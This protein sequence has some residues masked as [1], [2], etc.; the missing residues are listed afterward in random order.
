MHV[1][2]FTGRSSQPLYFA[3]IARI[4]KTNHLKNEFRNLNFLQAKLSNSL[5]QSLPNVKLY[6]CVNLHET[7]VFEYFNN[8]RLSDILGFPVTTKKET[9]LLKKILRW[10]CE[11]NGNMRQPMSKQ[12]FNQLIR[13]PISTILKNKAIDVSLKVK[14]KQSLEILSEHLSSLFV[15]FEHGDFQGN[16]ILLNEKN[17]LLFVDW[18]SGEPE[19]LPA[20]DLFHLLMQVGLPEKSYLLDFLI[21]YCRHVNLPM[22]I[23][24]SLYVA[25]LIRKH[26][27]NS[28]QR[29]ENLY[30]D[31][32][33]F[34]DTLYKV[35]VNYDFRFIF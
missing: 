21:E 13:D 11:F 3:K 2:L 17:H 1:E 14:A 32:N 6:T 10:L 35:P 18:E 34:L 19:G 24:P 22:N 26:L 8:D 25:F 7:L 23:L 30:F 15:T 5:S 28:P 33:P 31:Q 12:H 4:A 20:V 9:F 27:D 29:V 16:N